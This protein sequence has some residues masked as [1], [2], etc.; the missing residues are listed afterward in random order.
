MNK[1]AKGAIATAAGVVLLVGGGGTLALWNDSENA[2]EGGTVTAG[3]LDL[4]SGV[5]SWK[6]DDEIIDIATYRIVPGDVLT[7]EQ[8]LTITMAGNELQAEL[9]A[10]P[11]TAP[12]TSFESKNYEISEVSLTT[13]VGAELDPKFEKPFNGTVTASVDFTFDAVMTDGQED[14]GATYNFSTVAFHLNQVI[15]AS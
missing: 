11:P 10:V 8:P 7:Y 5:G 1:M 13:P 2:N 6:V 15:P 12:D 3:N 14:V 4:E 9:K